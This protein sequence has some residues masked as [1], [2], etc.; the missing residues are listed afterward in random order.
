MD[1]IQTENSRLRGGLGIEED[2]DDEEFLEFLRANE[3]V[4]GFGG[5]GNGDRLRLT[6]YDRG[7]FHDVAMNQDLAVDRPKQ[8]WPIKVEHGF[9]REYMYTRNEEKINCE[10]LSSV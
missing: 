1:S 4:V 6:I 10:T 3:A 2:I 9:F 5:M 8:P 7:E